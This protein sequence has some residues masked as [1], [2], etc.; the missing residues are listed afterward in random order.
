MV[1]KA[2]KEHFDSLVVVLVK[3]FRKKRKSF[4]G[5][6]WIFWGV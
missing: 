3:M 6:I 2:E 5:F 1:Q 4:L